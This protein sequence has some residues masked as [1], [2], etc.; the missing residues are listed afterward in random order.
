MKRK[1]A[2]VI[3]LLLTVLAVTGC[4]N[5]GLADYKKAMDKTGQIEKG[6]SS[7]EFT[8]NM[9][10]NT[11][12]MSQEDIAELNYYKEV[13]GSFQSTFDNESNQMIARNYMNL[14]GLG[15][16]FDYYQNGSE[17]FLKLPIIGKYM[18]MNDII[19]SIEKQQSQEEF[20][21][22]ISEDTKK[23]L[24]EEWIGLLKKENVFQG[25]DIVLTTPDGEV[26]TT[27]Y[28]IIITDDQFKTLASDSAV[29]LSKDGNFKTNV[30]AFLKKKS[31]QLQSKEV[32]IDEILADVKE[33][34]KK[35]YLK[36]FKYTA[37]VDIDGYIVN[38][39][40]EVQMTR[41]AITNGEPKEIT[42]KMELNNW[43]INKKQKFEF[44]QLTTENTLVTDDLGETM[45][46]LF[47]SMF[48]Q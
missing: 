31:G 9:D 40:I 17:V 10:F 28:T 1:I 2:I 24:S 21:Q 38:E 16:D 42:Y 6:Q 45:P 32:N 30:N 39:T 22:L 13:T 20:S 43:D 41:D 27:V 15:F 8:L 12:S 23:A 47:K 37:Y 25:K 11:D 33:Q 4:G 34:M 35:D 48:G 3:A 36:D 5:N 29:I 44:P 14:G 46:S 7:G 26:K 18:R 19:K